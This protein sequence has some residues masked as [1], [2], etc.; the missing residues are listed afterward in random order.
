[1][2]KN[3]L[4]VMVL[5]FILGAIP[6]KAVNPEY[7]TTV[8]SRMDAK[9]G[10]ISAVVTVTVQNGKQ[11]AFER[12]LPEMKARCQT[13][14]GFSLFASAKHLDSTTKYSIYS[15]WKTVGDFLLHLHPDTNKDI[16]KLVQEVTNGP[17]LEAIDVQLFTEFK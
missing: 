3:L 11:H 14:P 8:L 13:E 17:A 9:N 12:L 7:A 1:M 2:K 5:S 4:A 6:A 15:Q 10:P 16:K